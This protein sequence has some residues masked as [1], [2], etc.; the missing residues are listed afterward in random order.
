[1]KFREKKG[2]FEDK[3]TGSTWNL[4][5]R[6]VDGPM[7]GKKLKPLQHGVYY[8]F[9]WLAFRPDTDVVGVAQSRGRNPA[10]QPAGQGGPGGPQRPGA[11]VPGGSPAGGGPGGGFPGGGGSRFP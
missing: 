11:G 5:G 2:N 3:Q 7:K 1:L 8:A 9:A 6:A 10:I 4:L